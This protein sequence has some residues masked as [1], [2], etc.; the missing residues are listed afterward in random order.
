MNVIDD[1]E[2]NLGYAAEA[3]ATEEQDKEM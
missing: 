1:E 2:T 3:Q